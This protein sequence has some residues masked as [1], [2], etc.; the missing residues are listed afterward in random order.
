LLIRPSQHTLSSYWGL[1]PELEIRLSSDEEYSRH[2]AALFENAV[3]KRL[4]TEK[5]AAAALSGG[6]DSSSICAVA[7]RLLKDAGKQELLAY[8]GMLPRDSPDSEEIYINAVKEK[9]YLVHRPFDLSALS[10]TR[11]LPRL[12][13]LIGTPFVGGNLFVPDTAYGMAAKD[14]VGVYLEGFD[15]DNAIGHGTALLPY[16]ARKGKWLT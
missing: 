3:K 2:L 9:S 12:Q 10:P 13:A 14:E 1:D 16:L 8:S 5:R 15:G 7:A 6:L 4:N 11:P